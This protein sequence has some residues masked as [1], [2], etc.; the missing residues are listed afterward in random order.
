MFEKLKTDPET[1]DRLKKAA[2]TQISKDELERQRISFV[3]GNL[4]ADSEVT[5]EQVERKI[6]NNEGK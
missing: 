1:N 5:R 2:S 4:P 6:K 3:F